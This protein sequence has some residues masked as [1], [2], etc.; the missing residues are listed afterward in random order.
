MLKITVYRNKRFTIKG[1]HFIVITSL[2][3]QGLE[4]E[5]SLFGLLMDNLLPLRKCGGL[6]T[7]AGV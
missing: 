4:V 5:F 7:M 1:T 3:W 6:L 2:R